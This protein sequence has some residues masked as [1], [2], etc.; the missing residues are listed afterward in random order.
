MDGDRTR[1]R[2]RDAHRD[3]DNHESDRYPANKSHT[4]KK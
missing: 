4:D 1:D 3:H 2:D